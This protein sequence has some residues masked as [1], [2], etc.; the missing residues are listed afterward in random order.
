MSGVH[1]AGFRAFLCHSTS[2]RHS[3]RFLTPR[4]IEKICRSSRQRERAPT[5]VCSSR[6]NLVDTLNRS[7]NSLFL[8]EDTRDK[9]NRLQFFDALKISRRKEIL[10]ENDCRYRKDGKCNH[11][12][13]VNYQYECLKPSICLK[14][15][16]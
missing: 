7:M 2:R 16:R 13:N 4:H 10:D 12:Y 14:Q 8:V 3:W 1:S 9:I 6:N 11:R 15:R 5:V